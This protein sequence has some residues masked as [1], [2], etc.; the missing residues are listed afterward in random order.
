[1]LRGLILHLSIS[2]KSKWLETV[3]FPLWCST[4]P[5][6]DTKSASLTGAIPASSVKM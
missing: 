5:A 2:E 1:M 6:L 3:T 4:D